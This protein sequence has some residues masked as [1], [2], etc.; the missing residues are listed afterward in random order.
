MGL[1]RKKPVTVEARQFWGTEES[2]NEFVA[3]AETYESDLGDNEEG[4]R[5]P[6]IVADEVTLEMSDA[7]GVGGARTGTSLWVLWIKTLE[8]RVAC[9]A[10]NWVIR[11]SK[12]EFLPVRRDI[13]E[14][15]YE[16]D[17]KPSLPLPFHDHPYLGSGTTALDGPHPREM[18]THAIRDFGAGA[19]TSVEE[20]PDE[21][22]TE[23]FPLRSRQ[24]GLRAQPWQDFIRGGDSPKD[25]TES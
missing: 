23:P 9:T 15:T 7:R 16:S 10:G 11:G 14:E 18:T 13:F 22:A 4:P 2:A 6:I 20:T 3:W 12:D 19:E 24:R 25:E 17:T 8:G 5:D 21:Q 1:Y